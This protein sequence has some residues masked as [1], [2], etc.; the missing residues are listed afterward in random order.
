MKVPVDA[1]SCLAI[2]VC[3]SAIKFI[4]RRFIIPYLRIPLVEYRLANGFY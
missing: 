1:D 2:F 4:F 3:F